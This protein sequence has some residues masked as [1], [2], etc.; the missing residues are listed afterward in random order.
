MSEPVDNRYVAAA[1]VEL[2]DELELDLSGLADDELDD[3]SV[4]VD[5]DFS[6]GLSEDFSVDDGVELGA[7]LPLPEPLVVLFEDSRLS[8]R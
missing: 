6:A 8:L 3:F 7:S 4:D 5:V 2:D 1:A